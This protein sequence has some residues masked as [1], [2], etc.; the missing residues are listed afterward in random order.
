VT[1]AKA[2]IQASLNARCRCAPLSRAALTS[3]ARRCRRPLQRPSPSPPLP[4]PPFPPHPSVLA[5]ANPLY[6]T[7]DRSLSIANNV[8]LPDSL[9]SRFDMLFVVLDNS[10]SARDQQVRRGRCRA[11]VKQ[12]P[13]GIGGPQPCTCPNN[14][15]PRQ[16]RRPPRPQT[17]PPLRSRSTCCASTA[18]ARPARTRR[19]GPRNPVSS[20]CWATGGREGCEELGA[21]WSS[22]GPATVKWRV[23]DSVE[24]SLTSATPAPRPGRPSRPRDCKQAHAAPVWLRGAAAALAGNSARGMEEP[25]SLPGAETID[26]FYE[27]RGWGWGWGLGVGGWG[28]GGGWVGL[29]GDGQDKVLFFRP[30]SQPSVQPAGARLLVTC[31][32]LPCSLARSSLACASPACAF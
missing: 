3:P 12:P 5:A 18:T 29:Q 20:R 2:G 17:R 1:I 32:P 30:F 19:T 4:A 24:A 13:R 7:Y 8:N 27:V 14:Q 10:D 21:L 15:V 16:A 9:L 22:R 6:G 31:S 26:E 23:S 28:L 11:L 25:E